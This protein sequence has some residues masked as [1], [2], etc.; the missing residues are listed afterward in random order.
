MT[1]LI[2]K[3]TSQEEKTIET[4][5]KQNQILTM[6]GPAPRLVELD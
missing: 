4:F 1:D 6:K 5:N 3:E 2:C